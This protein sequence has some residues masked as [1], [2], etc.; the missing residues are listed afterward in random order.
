[1]LRYL[2]RLLSAGL[3]VRIG[4]PAIGFKPS[5]TAAI[6]L[7]I[8]HPIY[9]AFALNVITWHEELLI[10]N[11]VSYL[12]FLADSLNLQAISNLCNITRRYCIAYDLL[13]FEIV[14]LFEWC[15][16]HETGACRRMSPFCET[17]PSR[18]GVT[19]TKFSLS[20]VRSSLWCK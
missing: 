12:V 2:D 16:V 5:K 17:S 4:S 7:W 8:W 20:H 19:L 14:A 18:T 15:Q 13:H 11:W 10:N 1:M 9:S 3:K 6:L